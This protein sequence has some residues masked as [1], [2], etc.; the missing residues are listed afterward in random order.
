MRQ[1]YFGYLKKFLDIGK[2]Y[3]ISDE[4]WVAYR[5]L[6]LILT[7]L[8]IY[9]PLGVKLNTQQGTLISALSS[10]DTDRFWNTVIIFVITMLLYVPLFAGFNYVAGLLGLSWRR[11]LTHYFLHKYFRNRAYYDIGSFHINIDNPDQRIAED[12]RAFTQYSM[13]I[14]VIFLFASFQVV[15][16]SRVL[17]TISPALVFFLLFYAVGGTVITVLGFGRMLVRLNFEQIKKEANFRFSL[18]RIRE[19]AESIAFYRGEQQESNKIKHFFDDLFKTL[20]NLILWREMFLGLYAN[21]FRLMPIIL[22][23]IIVGPK[24]LAGEFEVGKV[25]E[26]IGAFTAVFYSLNIIVDKFDWITNFAAGINRLYSF[27]EYLENS[28]NHL[29]HGGPGQ[30][31]IKTVEN[32]RMAIEGLTLHTPN[33]QRTLLQDL[34]LELRKGDRLLIVGSSG[35]GKSSLL[36]VIAGLWDTGHG[37]IFRPKLEDTFFLPQRPYMILGTLREQLLYP[38]TSLYKNDEE[39]DRV[40]QKVNLSGLADRFEGFDSIHD[41]SDVLSLGEQQRVAFAR[42]L[43]KTPSY[44]FL[45]EATSALDIRNEEHLYHHL[46]E[47]NTTF[48]SVGHRPTLKTFHTLLLEIREGQTWTLRTIKDEVVR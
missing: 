28:E 47:A 8:A 10:Y 42:V 48:I 25:S 40:L 34:S 12:I 3:W 5:Y 7:L 20:R 2:L 37:V 36:R 23:A 17:W 18:A 11:W 26:A 19:H 46:I 30:A 13:G 16:F 27:H 39:L 43:L 9:T 14:F 22:P 29:V 1:F 21:T 35:C 45:D 41:W 6:F 24:V 32:G 44:V 31:S 33:Y 15:A 4:K 38:N